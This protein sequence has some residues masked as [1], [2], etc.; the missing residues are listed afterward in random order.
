MLAIA[1]IALIAPPD[2]FAQSHQ[3]APARAGSTRELSKAIRE[4]IESIVCD[5]GTVNQGVCTC[6]AG[7][8]LIPLTSASG[9]RC[10]R[11]VAEDC[12][13]GNL[14]SNGTCR[15]DGRVT[16]SGETY[17]LEWVGGQCVPKRC[18]VD[19]YLKAGACVASND[20]TFGFTCRT[21]YV[22]DGSSSGATTTGLHCVPDPTFCSANG[23]RRNGSCAIQTAI[24]IDCFEGRC[25]CGPNASFV[26]YLCQC[27]EPYRNVNGVCVVGREQRTS[28]RS[29]R[30]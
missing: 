12:R 21:G 4:P 3:A 28:H 8:G 14:A 19:T 10:V 5:G 15:C 25:S 9:G 26:N 24:A 30:Y 11:T 13:G 18:P 16:M 7:F 1:M 2:A 6:P 22:P 23:K 17:A 29:G 27:T 20:R